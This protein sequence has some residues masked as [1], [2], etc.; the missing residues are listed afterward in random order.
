MFAGRLLRQNHDSNDVFVE[1]GNGTRNKRT[2]SGGEAS[3]P[4][5][6]VHEGEGR[7]EVGESG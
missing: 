1:I 3:S 6:D 2:E 5:R 4:D 7:D